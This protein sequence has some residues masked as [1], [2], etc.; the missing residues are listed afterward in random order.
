MRSLLGRGLA[1]LPGDQPAIVTPEQTTT[2]AQ[3]LDSA[4][5]VAS[6][7]VSIGVTA[8]SPVAIMVPNSIEYIVTDIAVNLLGAVK[9]PLNDL[10]SDDDIAFIVDDAQP[11]AC[12]A[13]DRRAAFL[14]GRT[15]GH[16]I[17]HIVCTH[18]MHRG[19]TP[20]SAVTA[21]PPMTLAELDARVIDEDCPGLILY[22]GGTTGR[23]KGV[24]HSQRSLTTNLLVHRIETGLDQTDRLLLT[25]PLPH[26]AGFL[27]QT[28]L[29]AG[30]VV[31]LRKRFEPGEV[32]ELIER[33]SI[34]YLFLVPT[35][36]YRLLDTLRATESDVSSIRT[37][38]YGAAPMSPSRLSEGID[39]FGEVFVQLYGQSE[40]PNFLTRLS[41]G[42]HRTAAGRSGSCGRACSTV[43]I[44]IVDP[45]TGETQ[46]PGAVG[47]VVVRSG[48]TMSGYLGLPDITATT[49]REGWLHTGD[50]GY[51]DADHYLYIVDRLKDMVITGGMNVYT[52]EVEQV[53]VDAPGVAE[54]AVIG[55]PDS[56]WGEKVCAVVVASSASPFSENEV[57]DF[58]RL[59]LSKYKR[60]KK[61]VRV[62]RL[63]LTNYGKVDKKK[64]LADISASSGS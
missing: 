23:S 64:L 9:V 34:S 17:L 20:W 10:L 8:G 12:V 14:V 19:T 39:R 50:V 13:D 16:Q 33:D 54:V 3:L 56:D 32:L 61:Y 28:M 38:L 59:H 42:D 25:S 24:V 53:L 36:L 49:L 63:P 1:S 29:L 15:D 21:T 48:F 27:L 60:P 40:V 43:E 52:S 6:W 45:P 51:L 44:R 47:E 46:P 31:H 55:L 35:M 18:E 5:R 58:C 4:R 41:K 30:G 62:A 22:T 37:I 7:F 26:S 11:A 2:Y 57:D